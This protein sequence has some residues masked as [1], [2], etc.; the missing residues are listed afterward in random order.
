MKNAPVTAEHTM[1]AAGFLMSVRTVR[2][3][4]P[5]AAWSASIDPLAQALANLGA[6]LQHKAWEEGYAH[7]YDDREKMD[8]DR[9]D[10]IKTENPYPDLDAP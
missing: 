6:R 3:S 4:T 5:E 10:V 9:A 8:H 2:V 1:I 7:G